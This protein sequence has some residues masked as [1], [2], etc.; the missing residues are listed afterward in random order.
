[1][2]GRVIFPAPAVEP[3][4]EELPASEEQLLL[5]ALLRGTKVA[6]QQLVVEVPEDMQGRGLMQI[7][8]GIQTVMQGLGEVAVLVLRHVL[9]AFPVL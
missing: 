2:L 1:M 4:E 7:P 3:R 8:V 5:A 9:A 6:M